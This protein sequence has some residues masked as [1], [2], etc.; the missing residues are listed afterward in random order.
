MASSSRSSSSALSE[1][2]D[3]PLDHLQVILESRNLQRQ[4]KLD[5]LQQVQDSFSAAFRPATFA[6]RVIVVER[7]AAILAQQFAVGNHANDF[8]FAF[9]FHKLHTRRFGQL[10]MH[11]SRVSSTQTLLYDYGCALPLELSDGLV[12]AADR[13]VQGRGRRA[14]SWESPAGC[15]M[16][17]AKFQVS[18]FQQ[19]PFVQYIG[20]LA[21]A[22]AIAQV[23]EGVIQ[24][25]IKWPNDV[26]FRGTKLGGILCQ[27][28]I[29]GDR[30]EVFAG[31]GINVS[32]SFPTS[33]LNDMLRQILHEQLAA[34]IA[35]AEDQQQQAPSDDQ[36]SSALQEPPAVAALKPRSV[37]QVSTAG[38]LAA[39]C[40]EFE[41]ILDQFHRQGFHGT[42][43]M[44]EYLQLWLHSGQ[45]LM[46]C[47]PETPQREV[48]VVVEGLTIDGYLLARSIDRPEEL[49]ELHPDGNSL[50]MM[51]G[52]VL[53]RN[54]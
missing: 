25:Q 51:Q 41:P 11:S 19:L 15:L 30:I 32:N 17:T 28:S 49:H 52:L 6:G 54:L 44:D 22:R 2:V 45:R 26:L 48:P 23:T 8:D 35:E 29:M 21:M 20:C 16:F 10:L 37:P 13:Q 34:D 18:G 38:L 53:A 47:R 40:N 3:A 14:N 4:E 36:L 33:C 50:D 39:F 1:S 7:D 27:S 12:F 43:L 9:Y 46:V 5:R 42:S 24:P 31:I